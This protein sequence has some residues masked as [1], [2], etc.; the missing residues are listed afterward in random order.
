MSLAKIINATKVESN[1]EQPSHVNGALILI[2]TRDLTIIICLS[3]L[4]LVISGSIAQ[5]ATLTG[6]PGSTYLFTVLLALQTSF[7]L[8]IYEGRRWR[9]FFQMTLF[10]F[11]IIPTPIGGVAFDF[12]SK[13]QMIANAF[14]VDIIFNSVYGFY[15]K[16]D[17]LLLWS[18]MVAVVFWVMNPIFGLMIKPFFFSPEFA[19]RILDILYWILPVIIVESI[20]GGYFGYKIYKRI[21]KLS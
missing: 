11:L 7:S 4:G 12:F 15:R 10:T 13:I 14:V 21:E 9:F 19:F 5:M 8:L 3:V 16:Q 1:S 6:I 17:R 20:A 18:I 2:A